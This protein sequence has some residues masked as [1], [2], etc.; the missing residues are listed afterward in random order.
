M[1]MIDRDIFSF[2]DLL[3]AFRRRQRLTQR[4]LAQAL[5]VHRRTLGR[6]EQ[7][8]YLPESKALVLELARHLKLD[9]QETRQLLEASLTALSPYWSVP[10]LRNPYF[11]GRA[12]IL[13]E[14]H[15]QLGVEQAVFLTQSS[16]L[17]GLGG[18][19]KTQLALEYAYRHALE[20][21][22]VFWIGAETE[23]S[24]VSSLRR[25]A[26]VLQ[27]PERDDTDQQ[28]IVA[29]V[30]RWLSTHGQ[31][32]LIWDNV[33]DLTLFDRFLSSVRQGAML[34]TTRRQALGTIA[35]DIN[36]SPMDTEE[37]LL[38]LL[39]RTK[40]LPPDASARNQLN[41]RRAGV[42]EAVAEL[43]AILG[44]LPLALDQA[45]AYI[46]ETGC[47]P[48]DYLHRYTQQRFTLLNRRGTSLGTDHPQSVAT[49]FTLAYERVA[50]EHPVALHLLWVC[51][52]FQPE[53]IPE[54][55]FIEGAAYL[56][57][58][59]AA[60]VDHPIQYDQII[61][62]LRNLS[63]LQRHA[64]THT[65]SLHR[66][67]QAILLDN[68][69]EAERTLWISRCIDALDAVFPEVL[70]ET[71][72][73]IWKFCERLLA[74]ALRC[75]DWARFAEQSLTFA[76][77]AYKVA[78]YLRTCGRYAEAEP[79]FQQA[80]HIRE[81]VWGPDH[82]EVARV[83]NYLAVLYWHQGRYRDAEPL[84]KRILSIQEQTLGPEHADTAKT[85]NNLAV[86]YGSQGR[87]AEAEPLFQRILSIREQT[88][89]PDHSDTATTLNNLALLY[90]EQGK[91]AEAEALYVRALAVHEY[92]LGPEHIRVAQ[93]LNNLAEVYQDQ[94]RDAEAEPLLRRARSILEQVLGPDHPDMVGVL[95]NLADLLQN[96]QR[97]SEAEALYERALRIG[98]QSQEPSAYS[99][100]AISLNGL[101]NLFRDQGEYAEAESWY[102]R[103][104]ALCEQHLGQHHP[105]TAQTLHDLALLQQKQGRLDGALVL[106][107]RALVLR[108]QV[109]GEKHPKTDVTHALCVQLLKDQT[110]GQGNGVSYLGKEKMPDSRSE[111][112]HREKESLPSSGLV[113]LASPESHPLQT[114]LDACC[115]LHP[116]AW[117]RSADL[118]QAYEQWSSER[119]E[120]YP[121]SRS[122]FTQQLKAAGCQAT[123]TNRAR[124][125]R[126]I[127]L[128][129][130]KE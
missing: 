18:V 53:A 129:N 103:A 119:Q 69:T 94:G 102:Q 118:W 6:W 65:L 13:A 77:L 60:L 54:E 70:P 25:I 12:E 31:W 30:Q 75:L 114:F 24:I 80:I 113:E 38:F 128:V 110:E 26:E 125:W 109:L 19:G 106:A 86:L 126:G 66:L 62:V 37:G 130:R 124:I 79:F 115:D 8:D 68:M 104:L 23:E 2:G 48:I 49:T 67:V 107:Q 116:R 91:D 92:T 63:L 50:C 14:L 88:L 46:E 45:G 57:P 39:R 100:Q 52:F 84:F 71:E 87:Y 96:Q 97:S 1:T 43:V 99:H 36:L 28:R 4:R 9:E 3:Q 93:V 5:G 85:L 22:A 82:P 47:S 73:A 55:L 78:Q 16:A 42:D 108:S 123:R 112:D 122:A 58:N 72:H 44:G 76:S 51:A 105:E 61:A 10:L 64:E 35:R 21:S 127:T 7:G 32:L 17:H 121:L 74:H 41:K 81:H 15:V 120:R 33:E 89:G 59:V 29:S 117:C 111:G 27:L 90:R 56:G 101:A 11:T 95:N 20:Y 83:L 40:I 34:I 98:E